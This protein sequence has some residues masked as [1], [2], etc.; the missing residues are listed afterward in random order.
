[1]TSI[2]GDAIASE[3]EELF[4]RHLMVKPTRASPGEVIHITGVAENHGKHA[5][6]AAISPIVSDVPF[7]FATDARP[8]DILLGPGESW[9]FE[10]AI[11]IQETGAHRVGVA[12]VGPNG[13]LTPETRV[14]VVESG[15]ERWLL[16]SVL[17]G[18][19]TAFS[20]AILLMI[21]VR[22]TFSRSGMLS[23]L[24]GM[25]A[26]SI[27][28][29]FLLGT[30]IYGW[31]YSGASAVDLGTTVLVLS[32]VLVS[33]LTISSYRLAVALGALVPGVWLL[34]LERLSDLPVSNLALMSATA[35]GVVG[36][37]CLRDAP[38]R[39]ARLGL[40]LLAAVLW[41]VASTSILKLI[42]L[43]SVYGVDFLLL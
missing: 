1:M 24:A 41:T 27:V 33:G 5:V 26:V 40:V 22:R 29:L 37:A 32:V 9:R 39:E 42:T 12:G 17:G 6:A 36:A 18:T 7:E 21:R 10:F 3:K 25:C 28:G 2:S 31:V 8:T 16:M 13:F 23:L 19:A 34:A 11:A 20:L 4:I 14:V 35:A 30:A 43:R 38:G 15:M